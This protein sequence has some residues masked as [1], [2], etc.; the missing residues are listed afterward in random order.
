[1]RVLV[2][3][4]KF[5]GTLSASEAAAAIAAGWRRRRPTDEVVLLP[6]SDGGEGLLDVLRATGGTFRTIE[7]AGAQGRPIE[8]PMLLRDD[9][10]VVIESAA[11]CGLHLLSPEQRTPA[12]ATTYG[13]GQ[14]LDAARE[15]GAMRILVGLGGSA[16]V[17][18]GAGALTAMGYRIQVADGSGLKIGAEDLHRVARIEPRWSADWSEVEVELLADV[19]T[20]LL[21]AA[22]QFGPQKGAT[23]SEVVELTAALARWADIVARDLGAGPELATTPGSGAAGGLGF[24]LAAALGAWF[25]PGS[26][27]VADLVG[28]TEA[29]QV[30]DL[31][32]TGEGRLDRTTAAGKVVD[33]VARAACRQGIP[34]SAVVGHNAGAEVPLEDIEESAPDGVVVDAAAEV[35]AAA[36]RLAAR[37]TGTGTES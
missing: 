13:V 4:D 26:E 8:A 31:V 28:F 2:A 24:G 21:Q 23:P 35:A 1:M 33:H 6:L 10:S 32:I 36:E 5:G 14:L 29:L 34:T 16:S 30:A 25:V 12:R 11:A 20:E 22:E 15:A 18:G 9:G 3:P 19:T 37:R 7:V 17:D 27:R